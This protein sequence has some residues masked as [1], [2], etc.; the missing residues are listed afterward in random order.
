MPRA[1]TIAG[2]D[3]GG[4]AG[5]QADLKTFF[6]LGCHGMSAF[7][8]L[9]AQNTVEVAG[10]HE[11]PPDFVV[12]QIEAVVDDI[13]V[14][15]AKT[16]M[17]ASAAIVEAVAEAAERFALDPLVVD[18]VFVSKSR[19]TLLAPDAIDGLT[20]RL[21]P[22]ATL[23]TP[24]LHEAAAILDGEI[25]SVGDME[26]AAR[27]LKAFGPRSVLLKGGHLEAVEAVDLYFD[28]AELVQLPGTRFD[29]KD[30]HGTGDTLAAAVT[31]R[32]AHGDKL[33]DAVIAGKR[34]VTGAI[35]HSLRLGRGYGPVNPGW[36]L[37]VGA[38]ARL[39]TSGRP[40]V[41][42]GDRPS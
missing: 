17:L 31:A 3:S 35:E 11:V 12:A 21:F 16:G 18:P 36:D 37:T 5:V 1:L 27:A 20:R 33:L 39:T 26:E 25:T 30:T 4:G 15:A 9:T 29:T 23:V 32:L 19:A 34:F 14:D 8:A 24:N 40:P 28:G 41:Q 7:T 6:A 10:V 42:L 2:S 13:G 38:R 22:R